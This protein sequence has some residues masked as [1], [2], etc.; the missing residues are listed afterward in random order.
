[1]LNS[2]PYYKNVVSLNEIRLYD[3]TNS[4]DIQEF[5]YAAELLSLSDHQ[6][7][8]I[9]QNYFAASFCSI[10]ELENPYLWNKYGKE[11]KG[12]AIH[13]SIEDNLDNWETFFLSKVYYELP[14]KFKDFY[15]AIESL[16]QK[17][18]NGPK[19]NFDLWRFAGFYKTK[20]FEDEKEIRLAC[21]FPFKNHAESYKYSRKELKIEPDRNRIVSYIPL[22]LW[23]D[24]DSSY[25]KVLDLNPKM[26]SDLGFSLPDLPKLKIKSIYFGEN[27][28][29]SKEEYWRMYSQLRELFEWRLGY[30][31]E[32]SLNLFE[33]NKLG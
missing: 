13:F 25:L 30:K 10:E 18:N 2:S 3:L 17:Y 7:A 23:T 5:N 9:K 4:E 31:I 24:P 28:G 11:Y 22:K 21:A 20:P 19:F 1:L 29:L 33:K 32:L 15:I 26:Y 8:T 6:L 27:C 16:K 12:V 14:P